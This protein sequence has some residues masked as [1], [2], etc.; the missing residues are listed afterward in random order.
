[1]ESQRFSYLA[2][3]VAELES[4]V[5]ALSNCFEPPALVTVGE[6]PVFRYAGTGD[7]LLVMLKSVWAVRILNAALVLLRAGYVHEVYA[8]CR[9]VDEAHQDITFMASPLGEDGK[10]TEDQQRYFGEFFQ[11]EFEDESSLLTSQKP[12]DRVSRRHIRAAIAQMK[13]H[14]GNPSDVIAVDKT[15]YQTISGYVHG[16]YVHIMESYGGQPPGHFHTQGMLGTP[17]IQECEDMLVNYV[18]RS[19]C[20]AEVV[21][22]RL[23]HD[24]LRNRIR[25]LRNRFG[26]ETGCVVKDA[27]EAKATMDRMKGKGK[28]A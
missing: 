27:T 1:M 16:A 19:I 18:F 20:S 13:D 26:K 6:R 11:E 25:D 4:Y 14:P 22:I 7:Q 12:R 10:P 2:A 21:A 24:E 5:Q 15:L 8:L 28:P 23:H 9:L 3:S 17:K